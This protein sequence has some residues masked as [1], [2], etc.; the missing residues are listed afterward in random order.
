MFRQCAEMNHKRSSLKTLRAHSSHVRAASIATP[1]LVVSCATSYSPF[2]SNL[3]SVSELLSDFADKPSKKVTIK[4][5][6]LV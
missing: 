5:P 2:S 6:T 4:N 3:M 1:L